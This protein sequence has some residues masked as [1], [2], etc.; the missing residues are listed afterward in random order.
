MNIL[1]INTNP[2][3]SRLISLCI[4]DEETTLEEV[5]DVSNVT[6]NG[7][8]IVFVDDASYM[9]NVK[10]FLHT[11]SFR[12]KVFLCGKH[13]NEDEDAHF[14]IVVKKPFLPSQITSI[15]ESLDGEPVVEAEEKREHFIF[16]LSTVDISEEEETS[17]KTEEILTAD[18]EKVSEEKIPEENTEKKD[19]KEVESTP[20]V[21]NSNELDR[22]KALLDE[23]EALDEEAVLEEISEDYEARK[24]EVITE[25]LE[26]DG[27]E[28][29]R[30]DEIV[31]LL[32]EAGEAHPSEEKKKIENA[33]KKK[34]KA[35]KIKKMKKSPQN[36]DIFEEALIAAIEGMKP[37]KIRKLLK[38]A[39]IS[40]SISFKDKA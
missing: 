40:I 18:N 26:A 12:K 2:V 22:I 29:V 39:D 17:D 8:D 16:P 4:R 7:Y 28:I 9:E 23:D 21:L 31:D 36:V 6:E 11:D 34:K 24:V 10:T 19:T 33:E 38:D 25:H 35:K 13:N 30:E 14:D 1:L 20:E 32:S 5:T 15:L 3:V 27:L 37:K